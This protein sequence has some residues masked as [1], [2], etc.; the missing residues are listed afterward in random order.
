MKYLK[1]FLAWSIPVILYAV[2]VGLLCQTLSTATKIE[3][4]QRVIIH[5]QQVNICLHQSKPDCP[6]DWGVE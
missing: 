5:N 4:N 2:L 6:Q 3:R 1:D